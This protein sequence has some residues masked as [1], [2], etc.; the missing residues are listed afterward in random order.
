MNN[1]GAGRTLSGFLA[2]PM[3]AN[4][5]DLA[6]RAV[7]F[8]L[9]ARF[10]PPDHRQTV[11]ALYH[12][13]RIADDLADDTSLDDDVAVAALD[14]LAS[15]LSRPTWGGDCP[16]E[17]RR[18]STLLLEGKLDSRPLQ[19]LVHGLRSD[20]MQHDRNDWDDL[21]QYSFQVAG[22]VGVALAQALGATDAEAHKYA[23]TL[24]VAMQLTNIIRDVGEDLDRGVVYLPRVDMARYGYDR[25][26]LARRTVDADFVALMRDQIERAR[27]H[28]ATG[29]SGISWL[30]PRA[31]LPILLAA[32]LY[33]A[34]L[35]EVETNRYD[36]FRRRAATN[37]RQKLSLVLTTYLG[38]RLVGFD[39]QESRPASAGTLNEI[40]RTVDRE[41][42]RW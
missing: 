18:L 17:L 41:L 26:R 19:S 31:R 29:L 27:Q 39:C 33:A 21:R 10:L 38:V 22:S 42:G 6:R 1:H 8:N 9:A 28:Y 11:E 25:Q 4:P 40:T 20:R 23:A 15:W 12:F 30:P 32:R 5:T 35:T 16:G 34:I 36:V 13:C 3:T 14:R 2:L 7:S 24:G 37:R